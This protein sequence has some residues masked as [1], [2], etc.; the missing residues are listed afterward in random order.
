MENNKTYKPD[1][2]NII[3]DIHKDLLSQYANENNS[4]SIKKLSYLIA[5]T[6]LAIEVINYNP[7]LPL[8]QIEKEIIKMCKVD[9]SIQ[10][11]DVK[12]YF[13]TKFEK[14]DY[15]KLASLTVN[16]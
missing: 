9:S 14:I 4:L 11:V 5:K 15:S 10:G 1:G 13:T 8:C 6:K 7:R 12:I 16:V 3:E 2:L